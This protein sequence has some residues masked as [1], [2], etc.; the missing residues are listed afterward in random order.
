M[1]GCTVKYAKTPELFRLEAEAKADKRGL[2]ALPESKRTLPSLG[3][4]Q[5]ALTTP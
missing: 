3:V 5:E 1:P 2:W 4:V